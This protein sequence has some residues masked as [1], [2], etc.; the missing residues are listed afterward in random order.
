MKLLREGMFL[1]QPTEN[2]GIGLLSMPSLCIQMR[3]QIT[4]NIRLTASP[5]N[6]A[7]AI[8]QLANTVNVYD[9]KGDPNKVG[10]VAPGVTTPDLK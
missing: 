3:R 9:L 7:N 5:A 1:W 4:G 2:T 6:I 8:W 10:A